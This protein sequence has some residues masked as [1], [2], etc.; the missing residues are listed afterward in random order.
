MYED[1]NSLVQ[2][3]GDDSDF[4]SRIPNTTYTTAIAIPNTAGATAVAVSTVRGESCAVLQ[5]K[6]IICWRYDT[7]GVKAVQGLQQVVRVAVGYWFGCAIV[8]GTGD[9]EE[10]SAWCWNMSDDEYATFI[11]NTTNFTPKKVE[12]LPGSAVDVV[13]GVYHACVLVDQS[14]AGAV[15]CWGYNH[16]AQLGQGYVDERADNGPVKGY[17][18]PLR[19]KGLNNVTKFYGGPWAT[20]AVTASQRVL[21]W[22]SKFWGMLPIDGWRENS[23]WHIPLPTAM[24]GC[25]PKGPCIACYAQIDS[26]VIMKI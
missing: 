16:Y 9:D 20:C 24:Q 19:V 15:Y 17:N 25:A 4:F 8:K 5:N 12:G 3:W 1:P 2:C 18:T 14:S 7:E 11:A 13:A 6:T 22:G 26:T 10:G 23:K 21:C